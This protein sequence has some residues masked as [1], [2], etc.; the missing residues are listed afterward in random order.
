MDF[1]FRPGEIESSPPESFLYQA[2]YLTLRKGAGDDF[3]LDY[4]NA[5]VLESMSQLVSANIIQ[6]NGGNY[7]IDFRTPLLDALKDGDAAL[8]VDTVNR[9]LSLIP[10]DDYAVSARQAIR[11]AGIPAG[12]WL[13]RS[14][15]LTFMLG[16]GVLAFGEMHGSKGRSDLI[17]SY[18]GVTFVIEIKVAR[19][20]DCDA[21][22][23]EALKQLS[24]KQY[25]GPYA[26]AKKIGMAIDDKTRQV[27]AWV[28][29]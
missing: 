19:N 25:A 7:F 18:A 24:G 3:E 23:A 27:G 29:G 6:Q 11:R 10:Y 9:L 17:V 4:P 28:E 22:A 13:Y 5:E 8:F 21:L 16:C 20:D 26:N 1:A 12:E 14:S 2:G 15:I